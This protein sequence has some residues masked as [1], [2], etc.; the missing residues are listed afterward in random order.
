MWL[1]ASADICASIKP[2]VAVI[3]CDVIFCAVSAFCDKSAGV[4]KKRINGAVILE[5]ITRSF[6][7]KGRFLHTVTAF[8]VF[9]K[10]NNCA[11]DFLFDLVILL[12][13]RFSRENHHYVAWLFCMHA[14]TYDKSCIFAVYCGNLH[15]QFLF[16]VFLTCLTFVCNL[17]L[18][19][20]FVVFLEKITSICVGESPFFC[21]FCFE[22]R[23]FWVINLTISPLF[24]LFW[25]HIFARINLT[26]SP[27]R[28][29]VF[30]QKKR[31]PVGKR[32]CQKWKNIFVFIF[33][34]YYCNSLWLL[35]ALVIVY[36]RTILCL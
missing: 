35:T 31:F 5:K 24:C 12:C 4:V 34:Y 3:P 20:F 27:P 2:S 6:A 11:S 8:A 13:G 7:L 26:I 29:C 28:F 32:K 9:T 30:R 21:F 16:A 14:W 19:R 10:G 36:M 17:L 23:I 33:C 1:P 18:R 25:R 15:R 22:N